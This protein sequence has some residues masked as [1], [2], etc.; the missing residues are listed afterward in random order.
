MGVRREYFL[1]SA[2]PQTEDLVKKISLP[3]GSIANIFSQQM[4][5]RGLCIFIWVSLPISF[6]LSSCSKNIVSPEKLRSNSVE[7][8]TKIELKVGEN[9]RLR[10]PGLGTAG[11]LWTYGVEGNSNLVNVSEATSDDTQP[12][13]E[14]KLPIV[15]FSVDHIFTIQAVEPGHL[16]IYFTQ[17]RPWEKDKPPLK[18][19]QIEVFIQS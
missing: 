17:S 6:L 7:V 13:E 5:A 12:T 3:P 9:Y 14:S 4:L 8:P 16:T 1:I 2:T 15:G 18:K 10:L 19:H 11:Y